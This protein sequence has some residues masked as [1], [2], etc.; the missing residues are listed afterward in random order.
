MK[1]PWVVQTVTPRDNFYLATLSVEQWLANV[2]STEK[3]GSDLDAWT[4]LLGA[5]QA[6]GS[7]DLWDNDDMCHDPRVAY[8]A[9]H[10]S[11]YFIF[12]MSNNGTT[13]LVSVDGI[14]GQS[15]L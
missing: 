13:F 1:S 5:I 7:H 3:G 2:R 15:E 10:D 14:S 4:K 9:E 11:E 8:D 12:K 6:I